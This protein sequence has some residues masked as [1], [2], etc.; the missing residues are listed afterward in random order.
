MAVHLPSGTHRDFIYYRGYG[1]TVYTDTYKINGSIIT[2]NYY[3]YIDEYNKTWKIVL[4]N[5]IETSNYKRIYNSLGYFPYWIINT[6]HEFVCL[7]FN[8]QLYAQMYIGDDYVDNSADLINN[9][10]KATRCL[11]QSNEKTIT[12]A[13]VSTYLDGGVNYNFTNS[14]ITSITLND[15]EYSNLEIKIKF[16]TGNT[17]P[18]LTDN[19]GVTWVDGST[20]TL[21]ANKNYLIVIVNK[22]GFVKE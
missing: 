14:A 22:I 17:A 2:I 8:S 13:S 16:S 1:N 11:P 9:D 5:H 20:P 4:Y 12:T 10:T 21:N 18:T 6:A 7:P 15:C 19:S 3:I